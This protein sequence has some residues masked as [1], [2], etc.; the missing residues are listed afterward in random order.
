MFKN[1]MCSMKRCSHVK[2][3]ANRGP[4]LLLNNLDYRQKEWRFNRNYEI[5]VLQKS[6]LILDLAIHTSTFL[7]PTVGELRHIKCLDIKTCV[8]FIVWL[9]IIFYQLS[10]LCV[11][12]FSDSYL[13][14]S[15][16][17]VFKYTFSYIDLI[18]L[19]IILLL[20]LLFVLVH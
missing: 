18:R 11:S 19:I 2:S 16:V 13:F 1:L 10:K 3:R 7:W 9:L 14:S 5:N 15:F 4:L 8:Y 12:M 20:S 17:V 6:S